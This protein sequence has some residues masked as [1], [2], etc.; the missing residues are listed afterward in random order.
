MR[1]ISWND[2]SNF[3]DEYFSTKPQYL[4]FGQAFFNKFLKLEDEV[5]NLFNVTDIKKAQQIIY[6]N[7]L[8]YDNGLYDEANL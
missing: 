2:Y 6:H 5:E 4:R 8:E 1:K 7:Y 3:C